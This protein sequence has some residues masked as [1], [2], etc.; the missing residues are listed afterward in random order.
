M[1]K[2]LMTVLT[3]ALILGCV[4]VASAAPGDPRLT[5]V[6]DNA[7]EEAIQVAYDLGIV[8]GTP[9]GAYEPEKAVNRAEFA[10]LIVRALAV[11]DSA[12][13]SYTT[14]TFKDTSGYSWA[15]P[16]LAILQ[17]RGIMK[18]DG[19][20]NAMPGRTISPN[21]AVTMVLRAIGY[22]DNASVLVGQWP[23]NY[24]ALGQNQ[25]LYE[26]VAN[27]VQ[28]NKASAA[29]MIYNVLTKQLVQVDANSLVTLLYD[30]GVNGTQIPRSL[31]TTGLNCRSEGKGVVTYSDAAASKIDL[32]P[33]VGAYGILYRSNVDN[34]VVAL[35]EVETKFI[36][37]KFTYSGAGAGEINKF[38]AVDGTE[39]NLGTQAQAVVK[40]I[41]SVAAISSVTNLEAEKK[42]FNT[43]FNGKDSTS[44][45]DYATKYYQ[46]TADQYDNLTA[47]QKAA[48]TGDNENA[49]KLIIAAKVSGVTVQEVRSVAA[50]DIDFYGE[51]FLYEAGQIDGKKFNGHDFPL[52]VNNE[53]NDYGYMLEGINS[54]D[55]LVADNVVY[56]YKDA[57]AS[58]GG[59]IKRIEVGTETQSGTI[60]NINVAAKQRTIGGKV[61]NDSPYH[62]TATWTDLGTIN[63]EG[64]ALLDFYGRTYAFRLGEASKGNFAVVLD[65]AGV[66][67]GGS[68]V[69]LFDK[70]GNEVVYSLKDD[71]YWNSTTVTITDTSVLANLSGNAGILI[72]YKLSGGKISSI[73]T[74]PGG[75]VA[76]VSKKDGHVNASGN[77][78]TISGGTY[79]LDSNTLVYVK[80]KK[81]YSV[82][83]VKDL[84]DKDITK[85]FRW[86]VD[87]TKANTVRALVVESDDAG[88]QNVFVMINSVTFGSDGSS[89]EIDVVN[90]LDFKNG[91][92]AAVSTWNYADATL[93]G[94]GT[95]RYNYPVKFRIGE[96]GILKAAV[97]LGDDTLYTDDKGTVSTADDVIT[98]PTITGA[99]LVPKGFLTPGSGGTIV[100]EIG[101]GNWMSTNTGATWTNLITFEANT[102][103]YKKEGPNWTAMAP[104]EGNFNSDEGKGIYAFYKTDAKKA[105]DIIIKIN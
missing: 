14:S 27:D 15:V 94:W 82:G 69:K 52:D 72:E 38:K 58:A 81:D 55:E 70:T 101:S 89:G 7:N 32:I 50:W 44:V 56:I 75:Y 90:G 4:S 28:M 78:I 92:N 13:A 33:R 12:L 10:A 73:R 51:A 22:T 68:Q 103:L 30:P 1:K 85:E 64:T 24:V 62:H 17:Q 80:D 99:A 49:S 60:T 18:G 3:L 8:T 20:G 105:Y 67:L 87:A 84:L 31:L 46:L 93:R 79:L 63:N 16:Y 34:E 11:P 43:F 29:Q 47:A 42:V 61:L 98:N 97:D 35:T 66:P 77:I 104:S 102:V 74:L 54:L 48:L 91:R 53:V 5:D 96:D 21:E 88:A 6:A 71:V 25:V 26:N 45:R 19:Y 37:G 65:S 41:T 95:S 59:K 76:N 2:L 9:E 57:A 39:Y 23:A 100:L 40:D 83:S 36:A 86:I